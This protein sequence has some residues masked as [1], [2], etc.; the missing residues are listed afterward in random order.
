MRVAD[1]L[2]A[3]LGGLLPGLAWTQDEGAPERAA[4]ATESDRDRAPY[5]ARLVRTIRSNLLLKEDVPGNPVAEVEIVLAPDGSIT[6]R[7]L[8]KSSGAPAWDAAV[9]QAVD[10]AG[11]LPL[12]VDGRIPPRIILD[13]A[14]R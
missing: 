2:C 8:L 14:R 4:P 7:R 5:A 11:R 6:G 1:I 3:A 12:D 9:L 10:R 13:Y